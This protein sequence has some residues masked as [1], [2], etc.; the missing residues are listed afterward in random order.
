[1]EK[2]II[3]TQKKW[4]LD[5]FES[6]KSKLPEYNFILIK[7]N[8]EF[9]IHN[10]KKINPSKIFIPH[11]SFIIPN[12]IHSKFECILFHM[13]DLPFGRGGSPLQNLIKLGFSKTKISALCVTEKIDSG[14]IYLKRKLTLEGSAKEIFLRASKIIENMI[15]EILKKDLKPN[16][17]IGEPTYFKR[18]KPSQSNIIDLKNIV[19][20]YDHIRMLDCEDYPKAFLDTEGFKFE[21]KNAILHNN[22]IIA[23]VRITKK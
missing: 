18:R 12:E 3:L 21:F 6:C 8:K 10:V 2:I 15:F 7:N 4:H 22:Q 19:E 16:I 9:N 17:Q 14:S 13:T 5:L 23:N 1:M 11:W 20:I